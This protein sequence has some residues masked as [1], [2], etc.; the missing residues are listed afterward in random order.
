[1]VTRCITPFNVLQTEI[2]KKTLGVL[3]KGIRGKGKGMDFQTLE[4]TL[5]P[6]EG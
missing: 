5:T 2:I 4:K 3:V 6:G 1:L